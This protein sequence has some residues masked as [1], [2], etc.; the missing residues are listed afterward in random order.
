MGIVPLMI[1]AHEIEELEFLTVFRSDAPIKECTKRIT[2]H[3]AIE[4]P[5][6]LPRLPY[7][8]TLYSWQYE[9]VVGNFV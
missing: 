4:Q 7:E 9:I 5:I 3:E 2:L 8:L 1:I 6:N